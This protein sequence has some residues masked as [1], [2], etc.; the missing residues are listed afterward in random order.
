VTRCSASHPELFPTL[1][2]THCGQQFI[3]GATKNGKKNVGV[4]KE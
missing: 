4:M 1:F 3:P 2:F